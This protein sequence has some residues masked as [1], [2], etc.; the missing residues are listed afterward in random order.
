MSAHL[1]EHGPTLVDSVQDVGDGIRLG[2]VRDPFR[3]VITKRPPREHH[4][5]TLSGAGGSERAEQ[6]PCCDR[7]RLVGRKQ[8][9]TF[10]T[11]N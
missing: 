8:S 11:M 4:N 5:T 6:L 7:F 10:A 2:S 3:N 1:V 9:A